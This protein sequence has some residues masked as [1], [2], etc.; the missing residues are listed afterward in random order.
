MI[1][2]NINNSWIKLRRVKVSLAR[3]PFPRWLSPDR[4]NCSRV[5]IISVL[6]AL[7]NISNKRVLYQ[8]SSLTSKVKFIFKENMIQMCNYQKQ[9][10][11]VSFSPSRKLS[12]EVNW[13][14]RV[15]HIQ[16]RISP[17]NVSN[18]SEGAFHLLF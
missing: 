6:D 18:H 9:R 8:N 13:R 17:R 16:P 15:S 1:F 4:F 2:H 12:R 14:H 11:N 7:R 5:Y 3:G 10:N